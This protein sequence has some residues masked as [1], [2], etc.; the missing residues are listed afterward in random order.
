[1][2]TTTSTARPMAIST[3]KRRNRQA[4]HYFFSP[5]TMRYWASTAYTPTRT[6]HSGKH[7]LFITSET[8]YPDVSESRKYT[9]RR[10]A[11]ASNTVHDVSDFMEFDTL[12]DAIAHMDNAAKQL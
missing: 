5:A 6:A 8:P 2:K 7:T 4:G 10:F 12:A 1:M 9:V 3:I 11:H